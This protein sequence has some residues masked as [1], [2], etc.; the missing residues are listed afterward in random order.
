MTPI[1][2]QCLPIEYAGEPGLRLLGS[3][4][5]TDADALTE[6]LETASKDAKAIF[7]LDLS[8]TRLLDSAALGAIVYLHNR[9][10]A[11][12]RKLVVLDPSPTCLHILQIT[13][14]NRVLEIS[15]PAQA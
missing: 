9:L 5:S 10:R 8:Q 4:R 12:K 11:G 3:A 1:S 7:Y 2:F 14:L 6:R 15:T 13:A